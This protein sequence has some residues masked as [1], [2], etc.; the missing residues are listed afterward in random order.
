MKNQAAK[1]FWRRSDLGRRHRGPAVALGLAL[2]VGGCAALDLGV[3]SDAPLARAT[4]S[5][6]AKG[7][8]PTDRQI[9]EVQ[10]LDKATG[11]AVAGAEC[12]A[13]SRDLEA[14]F[15]APAR[16]DLP[17]YE[18][19][20]A[21]LLIVCKHMRFGRA[22][23]SIA[24]EVA[25]ERDDLAAQLGGDLAAFF[26]AAGSLL[27]GDRA[28][29]VDAEAEIAS[30]EGASEEGAS[31]EGASEEGASEEGAAPAAA[32]PPQATPAPNPRR[33]RALYEL[34]LSSETGITAA[35]P[36]KPTTVE[37]RSLPPVVGLEP[38]KPAL[39]ESAPAPTDAPTDAAAAQ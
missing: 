21:P 28:T 36:P 8:T 18:P 17:L 30:E 25:E 7:R 26:G 11:R 3:P 23:I 38:A 24:P 15:T 13:A 22:Q 6:E 39:D 5:A 10:T 29:A 12:E 27:E 20:T 4:L 9:I 37:A 35:A 1:A 32:A 31:E 14:R 2:A 19:D 16:L 34:A 33:Y